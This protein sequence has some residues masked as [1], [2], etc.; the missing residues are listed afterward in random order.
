MNNIVRK[1]RVRLHH[2]LGREKGQVTAKH[3]K[4][5]ANINSKK[6]ESD[7]LFVEVN[8]EVS[9]GELGRTVQGWG[10]GGGVKGRF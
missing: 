5:N 1:Q 7:S 2:I 4:R 8:D 3:D 9:A 6:Y 10:R